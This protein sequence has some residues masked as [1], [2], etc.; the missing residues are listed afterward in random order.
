[1]PGLISLFPSPELGN[2]GLLMFPQ[3]GL[4]PMQSIDVGA[5]PNRVVLHN[6]NSTIIWKQS[7][8]N[9]SNVR[10]HRRVIRSDDLTC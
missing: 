1:M 10:H 7:N 8:L 2:S 3:T 6:D 4:D 5:W 9:L